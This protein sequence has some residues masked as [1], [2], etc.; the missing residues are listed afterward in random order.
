MHITRIDKLT[1]ERW[2][3]LFAA[4]YENRG[5]TG[6]WLFASR[7]ARPGEGGRIDAVVIVPILR[8]PGEP[9]RLVLIREFRVPAG[10]YLYGLPAGLIEEGESIEESIRREMREETGLE[11]AAI[12]RLSGPL[13]SSAGLT[14]ESVALAFID[15]TGAPGAQA[16][17][18]SEDITVVLADYDEVD[19]LCNDASARFDVKLWTVLFHYQQLGRLE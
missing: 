8:N 19:R 12:K 1:D 13:L 16:L 11:V 2:L 4:T 7:R 14:D 10:G 3:N 6:R 17:D 9:P 5:Q 18:H 15:V